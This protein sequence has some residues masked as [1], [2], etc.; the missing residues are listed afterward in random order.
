M[1]NPNRA[2]IGSKLNPLKKLLF[3]KKFSR[4]LLLGISVFVLIFAA[5]S[6]AFQKI[7]DVQAVQGCTEVRQYN[8]C[9]ECN[10][11]KRVAEDSCGNFSV[12]IPS[13]PDSACTAGCPVVTPPAPAVS[14]PDDLRYCDTNI[15]KIVHKYGGVADSSQP[16]GCRYAFDQEG[17]CNVTPPAPATVTVCTGATLTCDQLHDALRKANFPGPFD[18]SQAEID[19]FN[20]AACPVTPPVCVPDN[21]L[22]SALVPACGTT[23]T[24]VDNCGNACTKQGVACIPNCIPASNSCSVQM[25]SSCGQVNQGVDNCGNACF[26]Q[27]AACPVPPQGGP[28]NINV[29]NNTS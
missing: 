8:E 24:G 1:I 12:V 4:F 20:R 22:C 19:G 17:A 29:N 7:Q 27:S 16:G 5:Q 13:Q 9:T 11:S 28:T 25:P 26:K 15:N 23:T 10:T 14:C 6:S 3:W 18:C 21:R 2:E